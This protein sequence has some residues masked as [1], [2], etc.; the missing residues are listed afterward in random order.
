MSQ[1]A[2]SDAGELVGQ[3]NGQLISMH[4]YRCAGQ[5]VA[6]AEAGPVMG[7]HQDNICRLNKQHAQISA[8][9]L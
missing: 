2:S 4:A 6:E 9:P 7:P 5:P 3:G 1:H 8:A